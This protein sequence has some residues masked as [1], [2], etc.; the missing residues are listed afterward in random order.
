MSDLLTSLAIGDELTR[1]PARLVAPHSWEGHIPFAYWLVKAVTPS[2]LVELG[3]YTGNSYFAFCEAMESVGA[4]GR[5]YAVDTWEGDPH[6]GFYGDE[7]FQSVSAHNLSRFSHFS[8]LLRMEFDASRG[9]FPDGT[10]DLLHIDGLHT[11]DAVRHDFDTWRSALTDRAVVIFHDINVRERGFGVWQ[12]WR[13][14]SAQYPAFHFDHSNGLGVLA[15]GREVP[16]PLLRLI[17]AGRERDAASRIRRVFAAA[18]TSLTRRLELD[19]LRRALADRATRD[20][21]VEAIARAEQ[22]SVTKD[23]VISL[24]DEK[25]QNRDAMLR[26]Y[27]R[28]IGARDAALVDLHA[29]LTVA[30]EAQTALAREG[31]ARAAALARDGEA[32]AAAVAANAARRE[33]LIIDHMA[34]VDEAYRASTSWKLTAPLRAAIARVRGAPGS[35]LADFLAALAL[36]GPAPLTVPETVPDPVPTPDPVAAQT[37][38]ST[39]R[40]A[41]RS[42]RSARLA[43]FLLGDAR[44]HVPQTSRPDV[45]VLLVLHHGAE[46]TFGCLSAL[47]ETA[48]IGGPSFELVIVDNGSTDAT[49]A[50]LDRLDGARV[51]RNAHNAHFLRGVNQ[52]AELA[53]GRHLLLLNND[54]ELLPGAMA[55]AVRTLD[56]DP[57]IGAVGGRIIL[58]DGTLQEAGSIVWRDGTCLGY[59]RGRAPDDPDFMFRRDVDYCSGACLLTPRRLF[60]RFGGFD[61]RFA[62]AYYEETDY[63][64]RLHEAGLR[65][66]FDPDVAVLHLEFGSAAD[67]GEALA[68]QRRNHAIFRERHPVWLRTQPEPDASGAREASARRAPGSRRILVVEDRLPKPELGSG[69]P[70][71]R[72]LVAELVAAGADVT[73]FPMFRHSETWSDARR[74]FGP[75]VRFIIDGAADRLRGFLERYRG[76]FD[77]ILVCRP[78]NMRALLDAIGPDRGLLGDIPLI[79]DAEAVFEARKLQELAQAGAAV[80]PGEG[81]SR[82]ADE[83]A[84]TRGADIIT[85]VSAAEL[86]V[87]QSHGARDVRLLGHALDATPTPSGFAAR[88]GFVFLGAVHDDNAPNADSLRYFAADILPELRR[89]MGDPDLR[90]RVVGMNGAASIAALDGTAFDLAGMVEDPAVEL[91]RARVLVV[92]TR[93]AAGIPH[94][95]HQA[96]ALGIPIVATELIA[97]QLGWNVGHDLLAATD[98]ASFAAAC[99]RLHQDEALW[100]AVREA[101]IERVRAECSPERFRAEI[102]QLVAEIP[103]AAPAR[104][105][106]APVPTGPRAAE[107]VA[108]AGRREADDMAAGVPFAFPAQL[109]GDPGGIAVICHLFHVDLATEMLDYLRRIPFRA[110]LFI[111]TDTDEKRA[112]IAGALEGWTLG[113]HEVR[114]TPNRG[115]DLGPMLVEFRDVFD[116]YPFILH[117]H[118]KKSL[119]APFLAPW[120]TFLLETLLGTPAVVRSVFEAFAVAPSLGMIVPQHF[121]A[122]R[123]WVSWNGNLAEARR[124][125]ERMG[126]ELDAG[127]AL[128]FP[129]GSMFWARSAALRPLLHLGLGFDDFPEEGQQVDTTTTHAIER[130]FLHVCERSGHDWIKIADPAL[131][132]DTRRIVRIGS[133]EE[134][135]SFTDAHR[136]RLL[137]AGAPPPAGEWPP[138]MTTIPP[139]LALRMR[140]PIQ[141]AA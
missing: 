123:R 18:G 23:V 29:A 115:R 77:A 11:Y 137:G 12:L 41:M 131:H 92:P 38:P 96:A 100:N 2:V 3:T 111:S 85:S 110:D 67:A 14:L 4:G 82:I 136:V 6:A 89:L 43:A 34:R 81:R 93:F 39:A 54:A 53:G 26:S 48:S 42:V 35:P 116:R 9:Y 97:G 37:P 84:L 8:S 28:D 75:A 113:E 80:E 15:V 74:V 78:H 1:E 120:R 140:A 127:R 21:A 62:P 112:A 17:E 87:F 103:V 40:D 32:R 104:L 128:D 73:F 66:V 124:L 107:P 86:Q 99:A 119:H 108:Y 98:A 139:G 130:L 114:V 118:G 46:L 126:F 105:S 31:E 10:V 129:S 65:V 70:R 121:D 95:V 135:A 44:L 91:D 125:G 64:V 83:V 90:L 49:A 132:M 50:L 58:P 68:L 56:A 94:K 30:H 5:A 61:E 59:G 106:G 102:R 79:Y 19:E 72:A 45:S 47:I 76:A 27:A 141:A 69:Y 101:S 60:E 109:R 7:I 25:L 22:L 138:M 88:R 63:C 33:R 71:A 52:A 134:I 24:V 122:I 57:T 51:I 16:P 117:T 55:A 20:W 36:E 13:E 133:P